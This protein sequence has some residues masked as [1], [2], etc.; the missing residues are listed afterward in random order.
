MENGNNDEKMS[1]REEEGVH[2]DNSSE[3]KENAGKRLEDLE[4]ELAQSRAEIQRLSSVIRQRELSDREAADFAELFPTLNRSEIPDFVRE[5]AKSEGIPLIAAYAVYARRLEI[6]GARIQETA[7][8]SAKF[9]AGPVSGSS[10]EG[11][12]FTLDQIR[13]MSPK[14]IRRNY[15]TIMK[16]LIKG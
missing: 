1:V 4:A 2:E 12:F 5:Q 8:R 11:D 14:E 16:S 6:A 9:S 15:K 3:S 7:N 10:E 13:A